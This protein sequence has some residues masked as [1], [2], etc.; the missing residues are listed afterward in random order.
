VPITLR[1]LVDLFTPDVSRSGSRRLTTAIVLLVAVVA[2]VGFTAGWQNQRF[3][4]CADFAVA[5]SSEP[6]DCVN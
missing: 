4:T 5:G 3:M 1:L 6:E 2:V